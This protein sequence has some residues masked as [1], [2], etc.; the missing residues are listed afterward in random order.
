MRGRRTER[1][2]EVADIEL[3]SKTAVFDATRDVR[4]SF[5]IGSLRWPCAVSIVCVSICCQ[6]IARSQCVDLI[7]KGAHLDA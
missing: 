1:D 6:A 5:D 4:P 3:A 2:A 7:E